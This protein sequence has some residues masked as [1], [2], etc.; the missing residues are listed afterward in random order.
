M[1]DRRRRDR[2]LAADVDA[3]VAAAVAELDRGLGAAAVDFAD[4]AGKP[5][6]EAVVVDAELAA[7]M[8]AGLLGR[9]HLD[10]D[11][12]GA[13]AHPRHVIGDGGVGD[14]AIVVGGARRHRRH[15]DPVRDFRRSDARRREQ[16]VHGVAAS[17]TRCSV[18]RS[19]TVHR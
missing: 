9:G 15:D 11:Q 5:R 8:P 14:C 4:Q 1:R 6:Q 12:A 13:A 7:A 16:D 17:R 19:G 18:K 10:R 2:R 3:G